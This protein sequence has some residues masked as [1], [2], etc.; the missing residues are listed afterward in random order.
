MTPHYVSQ[1][2]ELNWPLDDLVNRVPQ[3]AL[4]V[5]L[6]PGGLASGASAALPGGR[7]APPLTGGTRL[8]RAPTGHPSMPR[9]QLTPQPHDVSSAGSAYSPYP[10]T[11]GQSDP[12][13]YPEQSSDAEP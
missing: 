11:A 10:M 9:P 1:G 6:T 3:V 13:P 5:M 8:G 2:G 4:A 12:A 7:M